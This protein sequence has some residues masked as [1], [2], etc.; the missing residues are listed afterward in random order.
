M[1]FCCSAIW[2]I[3]VYFI[4]MRFYSQLFCPGLIASSQSSLP[5]G[6]LILSCNLT[7][8]SHAFSDSSIFSSREK[9]CW[10]PRCPCLA[11][12]SRFL[13][14]TELPD[15]SFLLRALLTYQSATPASTSLWDIL[16]RRSLTTATSSSIILN[17]RVL[18]LEED[19]KPLLS[20]GFA[21]LT[22]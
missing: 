19:T 6:I 17:S 21:P 18:C 9:C 13:Y 10:V 1:L 14:Q 5:L 7:S 3:E 4:S 2:L 20:S 12:L 15:R 22:C 8:T 11:S 16:S